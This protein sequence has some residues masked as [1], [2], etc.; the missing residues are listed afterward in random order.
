MLKTCNL[1][2]GG[3]ETH[4]A[5]T[6]AVKMTSFETYTFVFG[7][8]AGSETRV[9]DVVC[10]ARFRGL[11]QLHRSANN[12]GFLVEVLGDLLQRLV[13]GLGQ[14]Q[15]EVRETAESRETEQHER[16]VKP[17]GFLQVLVIPGHD[18]AQQ[19]VHGV[20]DVTS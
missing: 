12:Y 10:A 19:K 2:P 20:A 17:D 8:H 18:E 1:N 4:L 14:T 7:Q 6:F 16:L 5:R 11:L 3:S 9:S 13:L 15:V